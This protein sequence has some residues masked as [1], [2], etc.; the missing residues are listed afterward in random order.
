MRNLKLDR[1]SPYV[2]KETFR[3][4]RLSLPL[5]LFARR[6]RQILHVCRWMGE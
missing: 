1:L 2:V 3:L 5:C 4:F 6:P